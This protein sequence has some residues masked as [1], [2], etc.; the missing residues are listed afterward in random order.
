M[1]VLLTDTPFEEDM[2]MSYLCLLAAAA[3]AG[4][5]A[6]GYDKHRKKVAANDEAKKY[7]K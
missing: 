7:K 2:N 4:A 6:Y 5:G 1:E 3:A